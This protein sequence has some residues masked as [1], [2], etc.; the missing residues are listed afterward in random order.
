[1]L[2]LYNHTA[3]GLGISGVVAYLTYA[4][5]LMTAMGPLMWLFIFAPLGMILFWMF[6]GRNWGYTGT[7]NFYYAFTA[8]M[9]RK[10]QHNLCSVFGNQYR[11]GVFHYRS[12]VC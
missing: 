7:R 4:S 12:G 11:P 8:V 2:S 3:A 6:A 9:G 10:S 1:M 5:G